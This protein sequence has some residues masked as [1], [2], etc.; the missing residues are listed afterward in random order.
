M[1]SVFQKGCLGRTG[2]KF[3]LGFG[4]LLLILAF[5]GAYFFDVFWPQDLS[6]QVRNGR[7][8]NVDQFSAR[9]IDPGHISDYLWC[10]GTDLKIRAGPNLGLEPP[11]RPADSGTFSGPHSKT[12]FSARCSSYFQETQKIMSTPLAQHDFVRIQEFQQVVSTKTQTW[13]FWLRQEC[14]VCFLSTLFFQFPGNA[15]NFVG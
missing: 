10:F 8:M 6:E 13:H 15:L 3:G 7:R 1:L 9:T 11:T 2:P 14:Q 4:F 12:C 5:G